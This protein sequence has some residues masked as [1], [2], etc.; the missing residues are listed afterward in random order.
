MRIRLTSEQVDQ[1]LPYLI[2]VRTAANRGARGMLVAQIR[3]RHDESDVY[4]M[5]PCFIDHDKALLLEEAGRR[6]IPE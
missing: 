1:L 2:Q 5:E 3:R 4:V 6:E